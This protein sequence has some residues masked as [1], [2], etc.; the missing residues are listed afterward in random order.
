MNWNGP[1]IGAE[2]LS[3]SRQ[4]CWTTSFSPR[5]RATAW[6]LLASTLIQTR[7]DRIEFAGTYTGSVYT[8]AGIWVIQRI[9]GENGGGRRLDNS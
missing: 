2:G 5:S 6:I 8:F 1:A 7:P 4:I 9:F 3:S